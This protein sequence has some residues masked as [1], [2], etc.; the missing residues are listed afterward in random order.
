MLSLASAAAPSPVAAQAPTAAAPPTG[1]PVVSASLRV[2]SEQWDWFGDEPGGRYGFVGALLRVGLSQAWTTAS[3]SVE[4]AAPALIGLPDNAIAP[5]PRG[6]LGLGGTYSA[7]NDRDNSPASVFVKQ[8]YVRFGQP[9]SRGGHA[10]RVGRFEFVDGTEMIPRH[11]TLAALKRDHIAHRLLGT[12]GWTHVGR[13]LDGALYSFD[14]PGRVNVTA[15]GALPTR[16]VFDVK[17]MSSLDVRVGYAAAT[18]AFAWRGGSGEWRL[19][20]LAYQDRRTVLKTDNRPLAARQGDGKDIRVGTLGA[21]YLHVVSTSAGDVDLLLWGALQGG[22]WGGLTQR[23]SATAAEIGFQP[24]SAHPRSPAFVQPWIRAG[25]FRGSG[26]VDPSDGRNGTFFQVLPTPR[27]FARM[28]FYNLMNLE[29]VFGSLSLRTARVTLRAEVHGLRL[30]ESADLWYQ[31]GGAFE[32]QT[33][34]YVGRPSG[35]S[36]G[37]ATLLD[38]GAD[39]RL[40]ALT[41]SAYAANA[42]QRAVIMRLFPGGAGRLFY[43]EAELRR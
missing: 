22:D 13:S 33:F 43:L 19:F 40:G 41:L 12:F 3:W 42:D 39:V 29:D 28:P 6:Q 11:A 34:G 7:A 8:A 15:L 32:R 21:H 4:L 17:G 2:R 36:R 10:L 23:A 14:R 27:I 30:A 26:D 31:G 16:G 25:W 37:L 20:S 5:A 9:I 24:G 35:G 38:V 1:A 18:K